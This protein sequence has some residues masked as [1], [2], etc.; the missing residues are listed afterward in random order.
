VA[1]PEKAKDDQQSKKVTVTEPNDKSDSITNEVTVE[2][3]TGTYSS[4]Q[5]PSI[6]QP[7]HSNPSNTPQRTDKK[8]K[9]QAQ[10]E[11]QEE[12]PNKSSDK[13]KTIN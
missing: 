11:N 13:E 4:N 1:Q 7:L 12:S 3:I 2:D 5:Q 10:T 8:D 9:P 6:T